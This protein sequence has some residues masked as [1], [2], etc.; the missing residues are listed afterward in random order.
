[1]QEVDIVEFSLEEFNDFY[2]F[3]HAHFHLMV[4]ERGGVKTLVFSKL[5]VVDV[6]FDIDPS[7]DYCGLCLNV[8]VIYWG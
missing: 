4:K 5:I 1:M 8:I 7:R 6:N 3:K 2:M